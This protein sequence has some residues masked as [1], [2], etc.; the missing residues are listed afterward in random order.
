ML[1]CY[2]SSSL[3]IKFFMICNFPSRNLYPYFTAHNMFGVVCNL[4]LNFLNFTFIIQEVSKQG[5]HA[6][7][8]PLITKFDKQYFHRDISS[9]PVHIYFLI[10]FFVILVF[11]YFFGSLYTQCN[12]SLL[13]PQKFKKKTILRE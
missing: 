6:V 2:G 1:K 12:Y 8:M 11:L 7:F 4:S 3:I 9:F 13:L 5:H 10:Y